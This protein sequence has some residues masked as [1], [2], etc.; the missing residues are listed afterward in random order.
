MRVPLQKRL[1]KIDLIVSDVD[2]VLTD[3]KM[4]FDAKGEEQKV[5]C[6]RDGFRI[7][8]WLRSGKKMLWF[9]GRKSEG[10]IRRTRD[11]SVDLVFKT[12]VQGDLFAYIKKT[13]NL[14]P[15]RVLYIGDDWSDL[16]YMMRVGVSVTPKDASAENKKIADK[17]TKVEGGRGVLAEA[18]ELVMRAQGIWKKEIDQY[19]AKFIL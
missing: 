17:I 7:D 15:D 10:I 4:I 11:V 1:Q 5:F 18:V 19:Y 12:Q 8:V 13:Y 9:T 6:A 3:G 2:G 14:S 16:Y